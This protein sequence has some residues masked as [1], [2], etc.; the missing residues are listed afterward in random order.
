[1]QT[2]HLG[3]MIGLLI[4]LNLMLAWRLEACHTALVR[5]LTIAKDDLT[6][7][8]GKGTPVELPDGIIDEIKDEIISTLGEMRTPTAL[9]HVAGAFVNIMQ[10]REQWKIQKEASQLDPGL[11]STASVPPGYGEAQS[12]T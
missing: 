7:V 3:V 10:M 2:W 6:L 9:D 12:E 8:L 1:M 5:S 11:I 4:A